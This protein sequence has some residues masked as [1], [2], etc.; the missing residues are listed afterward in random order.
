M[1]KFAV[2]KPAERMA[3]IEYGLKMLDWQND[4]A[5]K[6]YGLEIQGSML[7]TNARLLTNPQVEFGGKNTV[8]PGVSGRWDLKGKKF[9]IPGA[10]TEKPLKSWG[11]CVM[12]N[13]FVY[14][15]FEELKLY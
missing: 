2:T 13:G 1:I 11:V 6:E 4:Q 3:A 5:F 15:L 14:L 12:T 8:N 10:S 9:L 7:K